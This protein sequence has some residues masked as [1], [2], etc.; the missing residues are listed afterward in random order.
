[1]SYGIQAHQLR[2][3]F[4]K[5]ID[6]AIRSTKEK[7]RVE[8]NPEEVEELAGMIIDLLD[9]R[10]EMNAIRFRN[11]NQRSN[12]KTLIA[13]LKTATNDAKREAKKIEEITAGINKFTKMISTVTRIV[14]LF[15]KLPVP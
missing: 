10:E 5:T 14:G 7:W 8:T 3:Q 1:M 13:N 11:L 15:A 4:V 12:I 6:S 9:K 2:N